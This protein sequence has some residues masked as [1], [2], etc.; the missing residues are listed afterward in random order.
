M[1]N[2]FLLPHQLK[3]WGWVLL[4][5][6]IVAGIICMILGVDF[7]DIF[8]IKVFSISSEDFFNKSPS[9]SFIENGILDELIS[10]FIIIGGIIVGFSKTKIE[11]EYI[12]Q[13][14]LSS[15]V[16]AVYVS[17]VVLL[18]ATVFVYGFSFLNVMIYNMFTVLLFFIIRFH[19]LLYKLNKA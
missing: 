7:G 8:K 2:S 16:W 15:L 12:A 4:I 1:N 18:L 14:R 19:L 11:D 5:L 10:I 3:K 13:L 17:C 9:F 6:G